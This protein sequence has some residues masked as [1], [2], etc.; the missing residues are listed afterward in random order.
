MQPGSEYGRMRERLR[1]RDVQERFAHLAHY[2][3]EPPGESLLIGIELSE[4]ALRT[5]RGNACDSL[6]V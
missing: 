6:P 2:G 5:R 3:G 4:A 1:Q